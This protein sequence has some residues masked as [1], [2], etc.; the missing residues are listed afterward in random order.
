MNK[1]LIETLRSV[2]KEELIPVNKRFDIIERDLNEVK[3]GQEQFQRDLKEVKTG[4]EKLHKNLIQ[5][6]G[7]YT[8]KIAEHVD[9]KTEAL[10]K[11]FLQQNLRYND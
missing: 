3:T 4:L 7:E 8:E 10:I 2:L 9:I 6:F 1:E 11:E 5:S